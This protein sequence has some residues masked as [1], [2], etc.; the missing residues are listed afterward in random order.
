MVHYTYILK[1]LKDGKYYIGSTSDL[2]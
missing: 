2:G 1:S